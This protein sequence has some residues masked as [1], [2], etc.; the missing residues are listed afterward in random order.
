VDFEDEDDVEE[1]MEDVSLLATGLVE[2]VTVDTV[3]VE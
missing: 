2:Y 3:T 1:E